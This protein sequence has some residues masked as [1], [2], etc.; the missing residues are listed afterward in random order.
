MAAKKRAT[1]KKIQKGRPKTVGECADL[2]IDI[3]S[4]RLG[5]QE[6]VDD[7]KRQ[8]SELEAYTVRMMTKQKTTK[9]TGEHA[10][11]SYRHVEV[12]VVDDWDA[13][14]KWAVKRKDPA[15]FQKRVAQ[16]HLNDLREAGIV[17][18]GTHT[19]GIIKVSITA[20][21]GK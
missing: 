8:Q 17:P 15:V 5:L 18:A 11:V 4:A 16:S 19:E 21:K 20:S 1:R 10:T 14:W 13:Y 9:V 7:L 12:D 3:R 6:Q 2:L